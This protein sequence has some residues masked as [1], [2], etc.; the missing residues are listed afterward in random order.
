[1]QGKSKNDQNLPSGEEDKESFI[2]QLQDKITTLQT[3]QNSS[4]DK[5]SEGISKVEE[6][7][8]IPISENSEDQNLDLF[9]RI[10]RVGSNVKSLHNQITD[11]IHDIFDR[12]FSD[13][14]FLEETLYNI[15]D[16][17]EGTVNIPTQDIVIQEKIQSIRKI[18]FDSKL[19]PG[20]LQEALRQSV[21]IHQDAESKIKSLQGRI[22][23]LEQ[24][25]NF[26]IESSH[27]P[28]NDASIDLGA[29]PDSSSAFSDIQMGPDSSTRRFESFKAGL[30]SRS[31]KSK[32][33]GSI[34]PEDEG[35]MDSHALESRV[36]QNVEAEYSNRLSQLSAELND[37]KSKNLIDEKDKQ[38]LKQKCTNLAK[39][40]KI[41]E[42][43]YIKLQGQSGNQAGT[44]DS[45]LLEQVK[46]LQ[47]ELNKSK[48]TVESQAKEIYELKAKSA[49]SE[50]DM[51]KYRKAYALFK[52][53]HDE[54]EQKLKEQQEQKEQ[55]VTSKY[56]EK[57]Q[58]LVSAIKD[59]EEPVNV[60]NLTEEEMNKIINEVKQYKEI[61]RSIQSTTPEGG[62][63]MTT[64]QT[65]AEIEV[66]RG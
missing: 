24:Q 50:L 52:K 15:K 31:Q 62:E 65:E 13:V 59:G 18:A 57:L 5:L 22:I 8:N 38:A 46:K 30:D 47:T 48:A 49:K 44:S 45:N 64:K 66:S 33:K 34:V 26:Y 9:D 58:Q 23:D 12:G 40:Y 29:H 14:K 60:D 35:Q 42:A 27:N 2:S 17:L 43:K 55:S 61:T 6:Q 4:E 3:N 54:L 10:L 32:P 51:S 63:E 53:K 37:A 7:L 16:K 25:I 41:L 56:R 1:M 11:Q 39:Q 19:E 21:M 36:R 20:K 28:G